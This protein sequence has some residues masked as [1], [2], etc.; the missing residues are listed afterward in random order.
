MPDNETNLKIKADTRDLARAGKAIRDAFSP[1]SVRQFNRTLADA[2]KELKRVVGTQL[3]L[4]RA[5]AG[6]DK[7]SKAFKDL[8]KQIRGSREEAKALKGVIESLREAYKDLDD[9][10]RNAGRRRQGFLAGLAQ[11][12]GVAQYMPTGPGMAPRAAGASIGAMGRRAVHGAT[13]PFLAPGLGGLSTMLG[14]IP[15]LGGFASGALQSAQGFFQQAAGFARAKLPNLYWAGG[16]SV[17]ERGERLKGFHGG[18]GFNLPASSEE[19]KEMAKAKDAWAASQ[20]MRA[21]LA[22]GAYEKALEKDAPRIVESARKAIPQETRAKGRRLR[23]MQGKSEQWGFRA[24]TEGEVVERGMTE[25]KAKLAEREQL[26]AERLADAVKAHGSATREGRIKARADAFAAAVGGLGGTNMYSAGFG[27]KY[28]FAPEQVQQML[29]QFMGARG[30]VASANAQRQADVSMA[31]N[32]GF[33]VSM[34]SAGKFTRLGGMG[35]GAG[36]AGVLNAA[37]EQGLKGSLVPEYLDQLVSMGEESLSQGM[38]IRDIGQVMHQATQ[39]TAILGALGV[40]K[41]QRG[42]IVQGLNRSAQQLADRGASSPTDLLMLR[43]AGF[44]PTKGGMSYIKA[45][46][47]LD[48]GMTPEMIASLLQLVAEGSRDVDIS[49]AE[50]PEDIL[51][52]RS[53][54][55]KRVMGSLKIP[56]KMT[57]ARTILSGMEGKSPEELKK[58]LLGFGE[59]LGS[60]TAEE[61]GALEGG[62]KQG[63]EGLARRGAGLAVATSQLSAAQIGAGGKL[64]GTFIQLEKVGIKAAGVLGQF[65]GQLETVVGWMSSLVGYLDQLAAGKISLKDV[66]MGGLPNSS[67]GTNP[68]TPKPKVKVKPKR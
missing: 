43:A 2:Q 50:G 10:A 64:A 27:T 13:A 12:A 1:M 54:H 31:A 40:E 24:P 29:G 21:D 42:P 36:L 67:G 33:G 16:P 28:G 25:A 48:K 23:S 53:L 4:S 8:T 62:L 14:S 30:G 7:G 66:L 35:A 39:S 38:R 15:L 63:A 32:V 49:G 11:G 51:T 57:T 58:H 26:A 61:R 60:G 68:M 59:R 9:T 56:M 18:G 41:L 55:M 65:S 46:A 20:K 19:A 3:E 37:V 44:D 45:M 47:K 34:Q 17:F 5:L 6:T 22:S 52:G